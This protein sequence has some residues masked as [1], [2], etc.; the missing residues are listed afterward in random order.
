M[1]AKRR[2]EQQRQQHPHEAARGA[3]RDAGRALLDG[4][5]LAGELAD[6]AEHDRL[7]DRD[8]RLAGHCPG[9][10]LTAQAHQP[11][12]GDQRSAGRQRGAK[13]AIE[14]DPRGDRQRHVQQREDLRQ[15]ANGADRDAVAPGRFSG[16]RCIGEPQDLRPCAHQRVGGDHRPAPRLHGVALPWSHPAAPSSL[17][18]GREAYCTGSGASRRAISSRTSGAT[19]V[20]NSSIE[21]STSRWA[22]APTLIWPM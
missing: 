11:A 7:R 2:P 8:H 12:D 3:N 20:A 22:T 4:Q 19:V 1:G 6:R 10:R 16:D 15:P 18:R 17:D 13:P 21:R 5:V 14:Q 9:E